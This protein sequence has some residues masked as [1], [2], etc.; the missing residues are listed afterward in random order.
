MGFPEF[1]L[2]SLT[3]PIPSAFRNESLPKY[4]TYNKVFI[5]LW[6]LTIKNPTFQGSIYVIIQVNRV[7]AVFTGEYV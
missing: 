4:I 5:F 6:N 1:C 3:S 2:F 7:P